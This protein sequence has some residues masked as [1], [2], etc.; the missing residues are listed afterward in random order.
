MGNDSRLYFCE[1]VRTKEGP[2]PI[3]FID[4]EAPA[5]ALYEATQ[6]SDSTA[7]TAIFVIAPPAEPEKD[8]AVLLERKAIRIAV[9]L[10]TLAGLASWIL[11]HFPPTLVATVRATL[12]L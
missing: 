11:S 8:T 4:R 5:C 3:G 2:R 6:Q 10:A 7:R 1:N 9:L 12:G